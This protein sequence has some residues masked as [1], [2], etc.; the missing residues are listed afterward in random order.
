MRSGKTVP[1][2]TANWIGGGLPILNEAKPIRDVVRN[3]DRL[4]ALLQLIPHNSAVSSGH[5]SI[6]FKS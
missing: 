4:T 5:P 3:L 1:A 2:R 6:K